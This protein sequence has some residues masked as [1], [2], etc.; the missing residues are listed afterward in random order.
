MIK[1]SAL[2][3]LLLLVSGCSQKVDTVCTQLST[4]E[5][6]SQFSALLSMALPDQKGATYIQCGGT[7]LLMSSTGS[8]D[9]VA[10]SV[11]DDIIMHE[12]GYYSINIA[13]SRDEDNSI[14][15]SGDKA[16]R[17]D[18]IMYSILGSD[19]EVIGSAIDFTRDGSID[20]KTNS[21]TKRIDVHVD[22]KWRE[23]IEHNHKDA[24]MVNDHSVYVK[25]VDGKWTTY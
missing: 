19:G 23:L 24:V 12:Q 3:V 16:S 22:G 10:L 4:G 21:N 2:F 11:G 7:A 15:V 20:M 9:F 17:Y 8:G 18:R 13:S 25:V 1:E 6:P 5:I 14:R